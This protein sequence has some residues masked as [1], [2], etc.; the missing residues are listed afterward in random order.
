MGKMAAERIAGA[1]RR[2]LFHLQYD[3]DRHA[4]PD[5][6]EF[7]Q[8][9]FGRRPLYIYISQ[10]SAQHPVEYFEQLKNQFRVNQYLLNFYENGT[11]M[12]HS[13]S[14]RFNIAAELFLTLRLSDDTDCLFF[15]RAIDRQYH[16][17][18]F[19]PRS[20]HLQMELRNYLAEN[21]VIEITP[22]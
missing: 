5:V 21:S 14:P 13:V 6:Q 18:A 1:I 12:F 10:Y 4:E 16:V 20:S 11:T 9:V 19:F 7:I 15:G 3:T 22:E 17:F 2:F 8:T